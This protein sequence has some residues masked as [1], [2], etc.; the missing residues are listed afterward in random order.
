MHTRVE[1]SK[2]PEVKA[3]VQAAFPS[4]R[5]HNAYIGAFYPTRINSYW[6]GGSRAEFALVELATLRCKP[7]PTAS[8]PYF[9][10]MARGIPAGENEA[11]TVDT[12]GNVMLKILPEG[13]AL[14]EAGT[15]CG[16][17]ATARVS[18]HP[19][20]LAKLLGGGQ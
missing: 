8:H 20:N 17:A 15:F 9:D 11:V 19:N 16:K 14:V 12:A 4:Y 7:L 5:K 13:I 10:V 3:V 1:L 6:D 2:A 18:L